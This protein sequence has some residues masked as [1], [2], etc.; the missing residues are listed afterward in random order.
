[1]CLIADLAAA[2]PP[3]IPDGLGHYS[4]QEK[5]FAVDQE[6]VAPVEVAVAH[7]LRDR[8]AAGFLPD[9]AGCMG[10]DLWKIVAV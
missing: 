5:M 4:P 10:I 9:P 2:V 7:I 8:T 6:E 1:M 3:G